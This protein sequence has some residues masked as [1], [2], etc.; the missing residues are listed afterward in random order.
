[1]KILLA[2][3]DSSGSE[4]A[5]QAVIEQFPQQNTEVKV[6]HAVEPPSPFV[7]FIV[8]VSEQVAGTPIDLAPELEAASRKAETLVAKVVDQLRLQGFKVTSAVGRGDS[9]SV[10]I[11]NAARWD[12]DLIVI[13]AHGA[14]ALERAYLDKLDGKITGE[15]WEARSEAW[16]REER[17]ILMVLK[18][19]EQH[20]PD[21]I[22]DGVRILE[23]ANKAYFL[24]LR[25][26]PSEQAKLLRMV[27]SNCKVD[28][29]TL[30]P[31]YGKPFDLI[32]ECT[33][34]EGWRARRES[35]SRPSGS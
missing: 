23:L 10:I 4:A 29:A 20:S 33:K 25:Q 32:F 1:M 11:D 7:K 13:G 28:A 9:K 15:F 8:S 27:L 3:D 34:K 26:P 31:S 22:L 5:T 16:N 24:Y 2:V 17:Q 30:Y 6:L 14:D 35:N 19:L 12:A 21:R 18:G